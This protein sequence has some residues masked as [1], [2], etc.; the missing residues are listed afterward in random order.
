MKATKKLFGVLFALAMMLCLSVTAFAKEGTVSVSEN[1]VENVTLTKTYKLENDGTTSPEETFRYTITAVGVEDAAEGTEVPMPDI[2]EYITEYDEGKATKEGT[3]KDFT[4]KLPDYSSVGIYTYSISETPG[5]SAGVVYDNS[6]VTMIVTVVN[7][8]EMNGFD[9]YVALKK[10][11]SKISSE[12][13]FVNTYQA[14]NLTITKTVAGNLG[15]TS[16]YFDFKV[17]LT[18]VE[19]DTYATGYSVTG[20]KYTIDEG[21]AIVNGNVSFQFKH[22]DTIT[23]SNLPYGVSYVITE[24]AADGYEQEATGDEGTIEAPT[25]QVAFTNTKTGEIDTGITLDNMPYILVLACVVAAG[26]GMIA[27]KRKFND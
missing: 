16:K 12:D 23:I 3:T 8:E 4:I 13:A 10:N 26:A 5:T 19:G 11:G 27:K 7:N 21:T 20:G 14:G 17:E 15:D 6:P 22:D 1:P 25:T 18:G 24:T 2:T 9:C